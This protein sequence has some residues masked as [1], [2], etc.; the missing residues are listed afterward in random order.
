[1]SYEICK[2]FQRLEANIIRLWFNFLDNSWKKLFQYLFG[3]G[4]EQFCIFGHLFKNLKETSSELVKS[5]VAF[6]K[7][8]VFKKI[9]ERLYHIL[10]AYFWFETWGI[11][12]FV[13][14][15]DHHDA[16]FEIWEFLFAS[17]QYSLQ[18]LW[19]IGVH[20]KFALLELIETVFDLN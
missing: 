16:T 3:I 10:F 8:T 9:C 5:F 14:W 4:D 13:Y 6:G 17:L 1:M 7:F 12:H 20:F 2:G 15:K 11:D 18:S 19:F